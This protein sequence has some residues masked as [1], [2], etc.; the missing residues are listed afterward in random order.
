VKRPATRIMFSSLPLVVP[1]FQ[2]SFPFP[3]ILPEV[4]MM[5]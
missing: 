2:A 3:L 5:D 4:Y 1:S